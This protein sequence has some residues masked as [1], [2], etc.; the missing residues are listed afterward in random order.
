MSLPTYPY[1][2]G[3][4]G[5]GDLSIDSTPQGAFVYIDGYA[6]TDESGNAM[7]TPVNVVGVLEGIH[8]I[9]ISLDTYYNKKVFRDV[10]PNQVNEVRVILTSIYY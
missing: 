2:Y 1:P 9:Q 4:P 8:E 7:K 10:I 6:L 5:R 3:Y